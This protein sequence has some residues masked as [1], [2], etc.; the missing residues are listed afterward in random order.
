MN[1][2][3]SDFGLRQIGQIALNA[4]D[5]DRAV[6]FYRDVLGMRFLF[7]VP[8]MAFF[9]CGGIRL[10]LG[11]PEGSV[12]ANSYLYYKV[13]D[14]HAAREILGGRG[15]AFKGE[16]H[17]VAKLPDHDLWMAFFEDSEGNVVHLM[18]EVRPPA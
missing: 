4:N 5:L 15:V 10:L 3:T 8:R 11:L 16:P 14:I 9:D 13:D 18:S 17:L 6:T 1:A 2:T 12:Q 7:R